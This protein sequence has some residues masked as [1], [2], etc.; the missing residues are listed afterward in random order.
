MKRDVWKQIDELIESAMR[1]PRESR[2][3]FLKDACAGDETL[4]REVDSLLTHLEEAGSFLETPPSELAADLLASNTARLHEGQIIDQYEIASRVGGGGMGEVYLARDRRL[5]R[6]V[7]LKVLAT[8][9][10]TEKGYRKRFEEEA[11]LASNLSHP[12][13]VTIYGVGQESEIAY[14]AMEF[15]RGQTLRKILLDGPMP[16]RKALDIAVQIVDALTA[17]HACGVVHRDLKPENVMVT[18]DG[19][20]KVLDFGLARQ[21]RF[22]GDRPERSLVATLASMTGEGMILGTVGYMSPEQASGKVAGPAADHFSFGTI[23]YEMLTGRRAFERETA[24]ET[25]SAII[26]EQP[27]AIQL[28][29]SE[30]SAALRLLLERCLAKDPAERYADT[31]ELAGQLRYIRDRWITDENTPIATVSRS[32]PLVTRRRALG[33]SA[34][35]LA[36]AAAGAWRFW[37][38]TPEIHSLVVLPFANV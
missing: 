8:R 27:P 1:L 14:M 32:F 21:Q 17:A 3:G 20:V 13:I 19:L 6:T 31:Q 28:R 11:R 2:A 10:A 23:L 5:N 33:L 4:R 18:A 25:L 34:A 12:N 29:G 36:A 30:C 38:V 22:L 15:V 24:V 35:G 16:V 7:A 9:L 26:R 37:P